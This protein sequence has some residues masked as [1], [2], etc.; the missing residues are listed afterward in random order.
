MIHHQFLP[1]QECQHTPTVFA[2]SSWIF[3]ILLFWWS[4]SN[5]SA[6][7]IFD[8]SIFW[9]KSCIVQKAQVLHSQW[10]IGIFTNMVDQMSIMHGWREINARLYGISS[11]TWSSIYAIWYRW[12][13]YVSYQYRLNSNELWKENNNTLRK[14]AISTK[15]Y[16]FW[17]FQ[18]CKKINYNS[19]IQFKFALC[20]EPKIYFNVSD[21]QIAERHMHL[22]A[23]I[24]TLVMEDEAY[25]QSFYMAWM[26]F[27]IFIFI[28]I[29]QVIL[30]VL[31]NNK[32]HPF[33]VILKG[34]TKKGKMAFTWIN[35]TL[36][37]KV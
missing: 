1:T 27:P 33:Q 20:I 25:V 2:L 13:T 14:Q 32:Y 17:K 24:D 15:N 23:T 26:F 36:A 37:W 30:F 12:S 18:S 21:V 34:A 22:K 19:V 29:G 16:K 7:V 11:L 31:Y 5:V 28:G 35:S 3:Y 9:I 4:W 10:E 6:V 8:N